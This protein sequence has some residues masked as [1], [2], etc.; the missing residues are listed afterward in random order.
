MNAETH[1]KLPYNGDMLR[2]ARKWRGRSLEDT[3]AKIG[4][5]PS[6]ISDWES[7]LRVPTVTQAR[8]LASFYGREFLEF[9]YDEPPT[10]ASSVLVPDYRLHREAADPHSNREILEIQHWAE[11]Q[12]INALDLFEELSEPPPI[13]PTTLTATLNDDVEEAAKLARDVLAFPIAIQ[14]KMKFKDRQDFPATLRS[15]MEDAGILVLRENSLAQFGVSGMTI[16]QFPLPIVVYSAEA[17]ARS[18]FT[19]L[20]ELAHIV[21]RE[22]AISGG[23][24]D[25]RGPGHARRVEKWCDRFAAAFLV[26]KAVLEE[27]RPKPPAPAMG[28]D[29]EVLA[30]VARHFR[31]S[32][33]AMLIRLVDLEYVRPEYYWDVKRPQFLAE[34]RA[35]RSRGIPKVWV[36]RI[37]NKVGHLYT[38]LV[39]EALGTGKI[40][41]HQAQ[42][43]FDIQN[44]VHLTAI[45][46]EFGGT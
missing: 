2:W 11:M 31:V 26:P 3:A 40:Q 12:R 16:V 42:R 24:R 22:S 17:P 8:K 38:G 36:S 15:K 28:M 14:Q 20:H 35:W 37:W 46:Q 29:D 4:I 30:A 43:Y 27:L 6:A 9:F 19:L 33:H 21:L 23:E 34:E 41:P 7:G 25:P 39:L 44:P 45:R 18:A 5:D 1:P 13:F 32:P 10:V